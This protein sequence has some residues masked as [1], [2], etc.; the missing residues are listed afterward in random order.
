MLREMLPKFQFNISHCQ[1]ENESTVTRNVQNMSLSEK[2]NESKQLGWGF[3]YDCWG[4][5]VQRLKQAH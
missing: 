3:S 1:K 4:T 5:N 2:K